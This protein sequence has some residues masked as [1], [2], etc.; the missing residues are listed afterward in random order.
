MGALQGKVVVVTGA[1]RGLGR[2]Y[3]KYFAQDGASVVLADV[4]PPEAAAG[5]ANEAAL[6]GA[7]AIA[8]EVDITQ[9]ASV[10]AMAARAREEFGRLDILVNNAGLW[11]RLEEYGLLNCPDDVWD[12]AWS[13][14]VKGSWFCYQAA[15]PLMQEN[16]WGRIIN[17]SSITSVVGAN[18]YGLTKGAVEHMTSGMAR[19]VGQY[20]ITVNCVAPGISAF[21]GAKGSIPGMEAVVARNPI[22]RLG[23][24]RDLY[25]AMLYLCGEGGSWVT[26][27]TLRVD[28]GFL[29]R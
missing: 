27:Q 28:G 21:E 25:A 7:R 11:R 2:D 19:E 22:P 15:V 5:A 1:A 23:T 14:N 9:R 24:S 12:Q 17:I 6:E 26:G 18:T 8:V 10:E 4:K 16:G 20:G 3:A 29:A 13:V